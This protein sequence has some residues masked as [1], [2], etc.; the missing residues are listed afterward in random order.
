MT[1]LKKQRLISPFLSLSPLLFYLTLSSVALTVIMI[2]LLVPKFA[3]GGTFDPMTLIEDLTT[4]PAVMLTDQVCMLLGAI[5]GCFLIRKRNRTS[6][7]KVL[8]F[9]NFDITVPIMLLIFS[10]SMGE[11]CD[12]FGGLVL[13][14]FMEVEPN[15][16]LPEGWVGFVVGVIGAPIAEELMFR[17][18][19]LEFP[20]GAYSAWIICLANAI[21]FA[22]MHLYNV[23]GF[24]NVFIGG[25]TM[26]YVY[27]K[28]RNL[29]YTLIEH[30]LHNLLC[31][32]PIFGNVYYE[33]NGFVLGQWWWVAVNG[34][35]L[36]VS[37]VYY[38]LYF[39]KKYNT[40]YF[41]VNTETGLPDPEF[42]AK[43][44]VKPAAPA[45]Y[46]VQ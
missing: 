41:K 32:L 9:Q 7:K 26:A 10:W 19:G 29:W 44:P 27:C 25:F 39:R 23:Q 38:F 13:S 34:V 45:Q 5:I 1:Q 31:L 33:K 6:F 28:T 8:S 30:A 2:I 20:R 42:E 4:N 16:T 22:S 35:L 37:L 12:H 36:A 11:V 43:A 3:Q 15:R 17:Y 14:N 24:L 21:Y 40:D 18:C 46:S